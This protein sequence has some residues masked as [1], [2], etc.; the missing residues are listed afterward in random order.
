MKDIEVPKCQNTNFLLDYLWRDK[1]VLFASVLSALLC[2]RIFA[3]LLQLEKF[4]L[5]ALVI[6]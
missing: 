4:V 6:L 3:I 5:P 2:L 1:V